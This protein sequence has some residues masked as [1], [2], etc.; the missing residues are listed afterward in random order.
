MWTVILSNTHS[1]YIYFARILLL[2]NTHSC[3]T[4]TSAVL[5][6]VLTLVVG[7]LPPVLSSSIMMAW[8]IS[9]FQYSFIWQSWTKRRCYSW[10]CDLCNSRHCCAY[11]WRYICR[12]R[13]TLV[14]EEEVRAGSCPYTFIIGTMYPSTYTSK[15]H[16]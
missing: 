6:F 3:H 14:V 8:V 2:F 13:H 15:L 10:N 4:S 12:C 9:F 5:L 7:L 16:H 11:C 1:S